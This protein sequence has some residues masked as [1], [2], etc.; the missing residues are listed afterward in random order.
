M[1]C[2]PPPIVDN[3]P[4]FTSTLLVPVAS[5]IF[6]PGNTLLNSTA[7]FADVIASVLILNPA[8]DADLKDANP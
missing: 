4:D 1:Y 2:V 7:P 8:I 5:F 3:D 6:N